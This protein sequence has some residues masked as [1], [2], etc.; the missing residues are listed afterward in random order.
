GS[1]R[2]MIHDSRNLPDG[3]PI[4]A[5][6]CIIGGGAA[7]ITIALSLLGTGIRVVLLESGGDGPDPATQALYAGEMAGIP[8]VPTDRSRSRYPG[9]STNGWG[10]WCRPLDPIDFE[11]RPWIPDSG[12]PIGF[13]DLVP[14][15]RRA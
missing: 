13:D 8:G 5:D 6:V 2:R 7:G 10:G 9:G 3:T 4:D 1:N 12:W 14:F 15:Y 11:S